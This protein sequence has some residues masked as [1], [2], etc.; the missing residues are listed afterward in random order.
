MAHLWLGRRPNPY[1]PR[2]PRHCR[3]RA[4][5]GTGSKFGQCSRN[6]RCRQVFH[7]SRRG[8]RGS[9]QRGAPP[10]SSR[11]ERLYLDG[12]SRASPSS[13]SAATRRR[14]RCCVA[15]SRSTEIIRSRISASPPL[16]RISV[17]SMRRELRPKL[18]LRLIRRSRSRACVP[19]VPSDNPTYLAQRER[20]FDGMRKA[21]V[22]EG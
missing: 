8:N 20:I 14:S 2:G 12:S 15:P 1:Q 5:V 18:G 9:H 19:R 3:M 11:Y 22:P 17:D 16:L 4:G 13:L 10:Q 21:G 6:D 7:R